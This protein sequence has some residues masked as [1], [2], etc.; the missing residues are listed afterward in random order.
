MQLN[1]EQIRS[2][3]PHAGDMVL[4]KAAADVTD[5]QIICIADSHLLPDNPLRIHNILPAS[6]GIEYAAQAM[7]VHAAL[8]KFHLPSGV[9][10][11]A[12]DVIWFCED[13]SIYPQTL[14]IIAEAILQTPL[15]LMYSFTLKAGE[16]ILL[17]GRATLM[18]MGTEK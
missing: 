4:L 6:A 17:T 2:Y 15:A 12:N 18:T 5:K 13:L 14:Q 11:S 7:A 16:A 9:L 10:A 8:Q 1:R 3:I